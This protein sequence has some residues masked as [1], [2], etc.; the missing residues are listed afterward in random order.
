M[1]VPPSRLFERDD[2]C[3]EPSFTRCPQT[4]L[5]DNFCCKPETSCVVL[6]GLT[7]V[8]CCPDGQDCAEI[9]PIS[10]DLNLQN[11]ASN[12]KADVK[13]TVLSGKLPTCG[14]NCC[15]YGYTCNDDGNCTVDQDQSKKPGDGSSSATSAAGGGATTK[16]SSTNAASPTSSPAQ[17]SAHASSTASTGAGATAA[18]ATSGTPKPAS[19]HGAGGGGSPPSPV[20]VGAAVGSIVGLIVVVA[21]FLLLRRRN[22]KRKE[23]RRDTTTS[24]G[25]LDSSSFKSRPDVKNAKISK[26]LQNTIERTD[27]VM[28]QPGSSTT[29][30]QEHFDSID[31]SNRDDDEYTEDG[32]SSYHYS[33]MIPPIRGLRDSRANSWDRQVSQGMIDIFADP[34]L[35]VGDPNARATRRDTTA[36]TWTN[37]MGYAGGKR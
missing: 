33:A 26:P 20:I 37:M 36:T 29:T 9:A 35:T 23:A 28:K 16:P 24:F 6:A 11:A 25:N 15:P 19:G 18:P 8:L 14:D 17:I 34:R 31:L 27:F 13:T 3:G 22:Q 1:S 21:G 12:P 30:A 7:T 4:G 10:C 32:R 5:P 2:T